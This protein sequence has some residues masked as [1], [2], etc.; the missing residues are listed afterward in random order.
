MIAALMLYLTVVATLLVVAAHTCERALR[1]IRRPGRVAWVGAIG[2]MCLLPLV[3]PRLPSQRL[4]TFGRPTQT[5]ERAEATI[6]PTS[7]PS[8]IRETVSKNIGVTS[9]G[10]LSRLDSPLVALWLAGS[11]GWIILLIASM[12]RLAARTRMWR[13]QAVDGIPVLI[14]HD[15]GPA[16]VGVISPRIVLPAWVLELPREQRLL[17]LTHERE[18]ARS[19]DPLLLFSAG[20]VVIAMPWN[21]GLWYALRRLRLAIEADCDR[22]VVRTS[23][24]AYAYGSLLLDVSERIVRSAAPVAAFA[25]PATDLRTRLALLTQ[26]A[27]PF[28]G[29]R[30]TAAAAISV[31]AA[32]L[33][34]QTPRPTERPLISPQAYEDRGIMRP[35]LPERTA[36]PAD[37][38]PVPD[39]V[40]KQAVSTY[41]PSALTGGMGAHP[42]L[43]F[44]ADSQFRV[45]RTTTGRDHLSRPSYARLRDSL[46]SFLANL[47]G[48][49]LAEVKARGME[50]LDQA[51]VSRAFPGAAGVSEYTW[52]S[53]KNTPIEVAWV[54][55]GTRPVAGELSSRTDRNTS[56]R[57]IFTDS[58]M[59]RAQC[60]QA[61]TIAKLSPIPRT[62][63]SR[64]QRA[65]LP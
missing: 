54:Q 60:K 63:T 34:C 8:D 57:T 1:L 12:V 53:I 25:E 28:A 49:K 20:L 22:R 3:T 51:A 62:C 45:V 21:P 17:L 19:Y 41:Y 11:L 38:S 56:T 4:T 59:Y 58:A 18:H 27:I 39:S 13:A 29:L 64:D 36:Q 46:P 44:L 42:F 7:T 40:L 24:D 15:T 35:G 16:L 10:F 23:R 2:L 47:S 55:M 26:S 50:T 30:V 14:S 65:K 5:V 6:S 9:N 31:I 61:D 33:A 32:T 48:N 52:T 43:W 37:F